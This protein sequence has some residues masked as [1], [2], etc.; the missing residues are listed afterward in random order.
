LEARFGGLRQ[1]R[2]RI[3]RWAC[4]VAV[5]GVATLLDGSANKSLG[6]S[7]PTLGGDPLGRAALG[8]PKFAYL[9]AQ[10]ALLTYQTAGLDHTRN[11]LQRRT[12][13]KNE[14]ANQHFISQ[15]E[16]RLNAIN[17]NAAPKNQRIY[18][19]QIF[20][21]QNYKITLTNDRGVPI[22]KNLSFLDLFS[23]NVE[24]GSRLRENFE[25]VF[26]E[27][28]QFIKTYTSSLIEKL[29]TGNTDIKKES[30]NL[31][32]AKLL[33]F[34]RNPF[35]IRKILN[36]FPNAASHRPTDPDLYAIF[37]RI[38]NGRQPQKSHL[39][40]RLG[41]TAGE[42]EAWLRVLFMLNTPMRDGHP[43]IL[44]D[45]VKHLFQN[46]DMEA[47]V[48]VFT[49]DR[50]C[51]MLSDRAFSASAHNSSGSH[52]ALEFNLCS[53]AF[54]RYRFINMASKL[55]A[56]LGA[57]EARKFRLSEK[58]V[59]VSRIENDLQSL[60]KFN[61]DVVRQSFAHAFCAIKKPYGVD[62]SDA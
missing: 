46:K 21:K 17:P 3:G 26:C 55:R 36:T 13:M 56:L 32:S 22:S 51:C 34:M 62:V 57:T 5:C 6:G 58:P 14:T 8:L 28:E 29:K 59:Q 27:H 33:G 7:P 9:S 41:V 38:L 35:C 52:M 61:E 43:P 48:D 31:F 42:Y 39:C 53:H 19:F 23:F 12:H 24:N 60:R 25:S 45:L 20:D 30:I 16:Q 44:R 50:Q 10:P 37:Q 15:V 40:E 47:Y 2:F 11:S 49:Y 4:A 18:E 1:F 54:I